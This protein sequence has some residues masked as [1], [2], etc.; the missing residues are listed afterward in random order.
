M[1]QWRIG[2]LETFEQIIGLDVLN[3]SQF[4]ANNY[5]AQD[6]D[7]LDRG[8]LGPDYRM[9]ESIGLYITR[10]TL[11]SIGKEGQI[12]CNLVFD[13]AVLIARCTVALW[14][15]PAGTLTIP[16]QGKVIKVR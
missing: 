8:G 1:R 4:F 5:Q 6:R 13:Y 2:G 9:E 7:G 11:Y 10:K 16:S 12:I 3:V 14:R 15:S